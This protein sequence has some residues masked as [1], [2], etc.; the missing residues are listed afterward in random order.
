MLRQLLR[1]GCAL[2]VLLVILV[3]TKAPAA[4]NFVTPV[5][6]GSFPNQKFYWKPTNVVIAVGDTVMWTNLGNIHSL[7]ASPTNAPERF[8]GAG[9]NVIS[10]CV[11][12]FFSPGV[13]HFDC[14]QR[15]P[16]MTVSVVGRGLLVL[17]Q[18]A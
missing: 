9:T 6:I 8:C 15:L 11:V 2:T 3:G 10:T 14:S 7:E 12:T 16:T 4:T 1:C 5:Q 17:A 13:F 18:I